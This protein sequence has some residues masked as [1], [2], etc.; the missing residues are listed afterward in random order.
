[1]TP[2]AIPTDELLVCEEFSRRVKLESHEFGGADVRSGGEVIR[3]ADIAKVGEV[4]LRRFIFERLRPDIIVK[5]DL[6]IHTEEEKRRVIGGIEIN[7]QKFKVKSIREGGSHLL[8]DLPYL[9]WAKKYSKLPDF[10]VA[11]EVGWDH[12]AKYAPT[13]WAKIHG[14]IAVSD[15][16]NVEHIDGDVSLLCA[17]LTN[18][19]L[20][21]EGGELGVTGLRLQAATCVVPCSRLSQD[22]IGVLRIQ[23]GL[24]AC[25]IAAEPEPVGSGIDWSERH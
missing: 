19:K 25:E 16:V 2:I 3:D 9:Q 13:G 6:A 21:R 14:F 15:V 17:G 8:V 1:M 12:A 4:A 5:V 7:D 24:F 10:F 11:V 18:A 20:V 22:W 23:P